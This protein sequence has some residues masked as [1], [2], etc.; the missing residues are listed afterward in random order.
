MYFFYIFL[1]ILINLIT[2]KNNILDFLINLKLK[3]KKFNFL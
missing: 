2:I 3:K 1:N